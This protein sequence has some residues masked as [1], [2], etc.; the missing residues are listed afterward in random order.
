MNSIKKA[1]L[2]LTLAWVAIAANAVPSLRRELE[3]PQPDGNDVT[4]ILSGDEHSH[5]FLTID[6]IPVLKTA[7]GYVYADWDGKE[8][9]PSAVLAHNPGERSASEASYA[10][11]KDAAL[12]ALSDIREA[13]MQKA[14]AR[15]AKRVVR[16]VGDVGHYEGSKKGLVILVNFTDLKMSEIGTRDFFDRMFNQEGFS[17]YEAAGSVHDY[18]RDQSYGKFDL[19]FDV[20]GPVTVSKEMKYYGENDGSGNDMHPEEMVAEAC[21]LV[22]SQVNFKDYDWDGDGEVDQVYVIYAGHGEHAGASDDTIWP[23]ESVLW[24][25][26]LVLDDVR[27]YTYACSCE[28]RGRNGTKPNGIGTACHEFSHCLGFP[29]LYDTDYSGAFGMSY[30]DVMD[31]GSYCGPSGYGE[32]PSGYS[33][34]ERWMAGWLTPTTISDD[35]E[36][37]G[38]KCLGDKPEA[39]ALYND[40]NK[41]ELYLLENRQSK[42]WFRYVDNY[43][44]FHG[45]LVTHINYDYRSWSTNRVNPD[46]E[47]MHYSIIPADNSYGSSRTEYSGDLFPG[48]SNVTRLTNDSHTSS[49]G[50]LFNKNSLGTNDLNLALIDIA[51]DGENISFKVVNCKNFSIPNPIKVTDIDEEGYTLHWEAVADAESYVVEIAYDT[52]V[53]G[54]IPLTRT[55][56]IENLH[57]TSVRTNWNETTGKTKF[58]VYAN[59]K[60]LQTQ[61][62]SYMEIP[63][64]SGVEEIS[65]DDPDVEIYG[66]DGVRRSELGEGVNI[67][68]KGNKVIKVLGRKNR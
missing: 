57:E 24:S 59:I 28:L 66:I 35:A 21:K 63:K 42:G 39:Y 3:F 19:K 60:G 26:R 8:I 67:V 49:G 46:P 1:L 56:R 53:N 9:K 5:Y 64:N 12:A 43:T 31:S 50:K 37:K 13:S 2:T 68:R 48:T 44:G 7:A 25:E 11:N 51:E 38:M 22:D 17:E 10:E 4:L 40:A 29:D 58:R 6:G 30:W 36:V 45:L 15:R 65:L 18:F 23:H 47:N 52:M 62:S 32:V 41:N 55:R 27:I 61:W 16:K 20:V 34:Y 14:N 33:A 54:V